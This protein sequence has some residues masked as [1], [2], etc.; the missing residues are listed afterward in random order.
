MI[1]PVFAWTISDPDAFEVVDQ[2]KNLRLYCR[3]A[4]DYTV[5]LQA[6]DAEG[7]VL[8]TR[9]AVHVAPGE[10]EPAISLAADGGSGNGVFDAD[11]Q[12]ELTLKIDGVQ[13]ILSAEWSAP[14]FIS[15]SGAGIHRAAAFAQPGTGTV[16]VAARVIDSEGK[17]LTLEASCDLEAVRMPRYTRSS[18]LEESGEYLLVSRSG[19]ALSSSIKT[20]SGIQVFV[21]AEGLDG[22]SL[23]DPENEISGQHHDLVWKL[24]PAAGG[25]WTIQ[26]SGSGKYL[27]LSPSSRSISLSDTPVELSIETAPWTGGGQCIAIHNGSMYL[28]HSSSKGGFCG[29]SGETIAGAN[30][31]FVLYHLQPQPVRPEEKA[32]LRLLE[33]AVSYARVLSLPQTL[34]PAVRSEFEQALEQ[35][36]TVLAAEDCSQ[37]QADEAWTRL[38]QAVHMLGF[39]SD[40]SELLERIAEA[41]LLSSDSYTPESWAVFEEALEAARQTAQDET[42]LDERIE[43]VLNALNQAMNALQP[44]GVIDTSLLAVLVSICDAADLSLYIEQGKEA[45]EESLAR[46]RAILENPHSQSEVDQAAARLHA[47]WLELRLA[48]DEGMLAELT[49]FAHTLRTISMDSYSTSLQSDLKQFRER[50][51]AA[52]SDENLTREEA[53]V[54]IAQKVELEIRMGQEQ[55]RA[56]T[57]GNPIRTSSTRTSSVKTAAGLHRNGTAAL[58][59]CAAV[60]LAL[61]GRKRNRK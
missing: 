41:E 34:H 59:G 14:S 38:C 33:Q 51:D 48:P 16:R 17:E 52:L 61:L 21:P 9:T 43:R 31:Q 28:N 3:K 7:H 46:A 58:A 57:A 50:L 27:S 19:N 24:T 30:N 47:D 1:N 15:I 42:A 25:K 40:K 5:T 26:H 18:L 55:S 45:F 56:D 23:N 53:S 10:G 20:A 4:G 60:M 39:T 11:K 2:G 12:A 22:L 29:Y 36:Q 13:E 37:Q 6:E 32:D 35:A 8:Q 44:S 54:L 49:A